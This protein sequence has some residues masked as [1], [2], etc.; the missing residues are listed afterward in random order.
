MVVESFSDVQV[1]K[2]RHALGLDRVKVA[3]RNTYVAADDQDWNKL[4]ERGFAEKH[5]SPFSED[6]VYRL[7]KQA[8]FFFLNEGESLDDK[9]RFPVIG[10]YPECKIEGY[11]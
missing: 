1:A 2:G 10:T 6:F 5:K 9:L 4:V 7:S 8:A 11:A 3:Y